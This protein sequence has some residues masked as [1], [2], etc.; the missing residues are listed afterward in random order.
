MVVRPAGP[1]GFTRR[2][3]IRQPLPSGHTSAAGKVHWQPLAWITP[4]AEADKRADRRT[5]S[6]MGSTKPYSRM[7][8]AVTAA[9][10]ARN[11]ARGGPSST[12]P[13]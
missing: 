8:A 2:L 6:A 11:R 4:M 5:P 12:C 1:T 7:A 9:S 13:L 10:F 3:N